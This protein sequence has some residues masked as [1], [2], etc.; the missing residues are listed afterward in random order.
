MLSL[1]TV[2]IEKLLSLLTE[3]SSTDSSNNSSTNN[4]TTTTTTPISGITSSNVTSVHAITVKD[5]VL[6]II[7]CVIHE[8]LHSSQELHRIQ[9]ALQSS[10]LVKVICH[11]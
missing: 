9:L 3:D 8:S 4:D 5:D 11:I 6:P 2:F 7:V 10:I 1:F